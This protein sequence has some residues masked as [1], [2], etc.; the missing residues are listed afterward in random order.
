MDC[1][2]P[3]KPVASQCK[4][5]GLRRLRRRSGGAGREGREGRDLNS[6]RWPAEAGAPN[7]SPQ[8]SGDWD[9]TR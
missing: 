6:E 1:R 3:S 5:A 7:T 9:H 4:L 2:K 8:E